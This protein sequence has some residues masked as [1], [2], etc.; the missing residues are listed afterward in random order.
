MT[1]QQSLPHQ[2]IGKRI[3]A[4]ALAL[5]SLVV[6]VP[7]AT[8]DTADTSAPVVDWKPCPTYSDDVLRY[9]GVPADRLPA[10]R[11]L[12]NRMECGTAAVPVD[13]RRPRGK[14]I[15]VAFTRLKAVN[16]ARRLGALALNPG[17]PGGSGYLMP[18]DVSL[19]NVE[20]AKLNERYDLIGFDP[21]GVG[22]STTVNCEP[23]ARGPAP[24][25]P[26]TKAAAKE[27]YDREVAANK[28]CG[29]SDPEFLGQ[30]TTENVARDLD[31]IRAG[32]GERK[33]NFLG[34]S[35][36]TWLGAVY[37]SAF[38]ASAGRVFLD[39]VAPPHWR[40]D[41]F[42]NA[43]AAATERV[44][45]RMMEWLAQRN[46]TYGF[47]TTA[48]QVKAAIMALGRDFDANPRNFTDLPLPV[49]GEVIAV[50]TLQPSPVWPEAAQV[51][52]ELRDAT[53]PT[54][55]PTV[56]QV[57][58]G[59]PRPPAPPGTPAQANPV[60]GRATLCNEDPSRLGFDA[61]WADYQRL[62]T[63]N[64]LTGRTTRFSANCAGWPL[65]VQE[66]QVRHGNGPLVLAG[67]RN[68][69]VSVFEW[70]AEMRKAVGGKVYTVEDDVHGSV[71]R[72]PECA[73]DLVGFFNTGRIDKGCA[74]VPAPQT[75]TA[76]QEFR[77]DLTA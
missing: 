66:Y 20:T 56:K 51:L 47:G 49:N 54:A 10:Y 16:Q 77:L 22:Y 75:T 61:A 28:A 74:G 43:R 35:W 8:A 44:A 37:R 67:H 30:L 23:P 5:T 11:A 52:K 17:G 39:S 15:T 46:D 48:A 6:G 40:F 21:R 50:S 60:M 41:E 25:W 58:G 71:L 53:G 76:T 57:L 1:R 33:L 34:I 73:A 3:A 12:L 70:T 69:A 26:L 4:V 18:L 63:G 7:A 68:E 36:G 27:M 13:Y 65:P 45:G 31:R 62:V 14:Q 72:V 38:P 9:R 55:P 59:G 2:H 32:L 24:T 29:Q 42:V 19:A 64:Q